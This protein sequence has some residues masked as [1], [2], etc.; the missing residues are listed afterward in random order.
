VASINNG[1]SDAKALGS[2]IFDDLK[3]EFA[4]LR[5]VRSQFGYILIDPR[6]VSLS[7]DNR[8]LRNVF[9]RSGLDHRNSDHWK[10]LLSVVAGALYPPRSDA[11]ARANERKKKWNIESTRAFFL[12]V[13]R[14]F[15]ET[16]KSII[17]IC[18]DL[19]ALAVDQPDSPYRAPSARALENKFSVLLGEAEA[20]LREANESWLGIDRAELQNLIEKI[21]AE[22][23][24]QR[25]K[26]AK[27][28]TRKERK[29]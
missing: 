5:I 24:E 6:T 20:H 27:L 11:A 1:I 2:R 7:K 17:S 21:K 29:S 22:R 12:E 3:A 15:I 14:T 16:G 9:K 26:R 10:Y 13:A 25:K 19:K 23:T 18:T 28:G 4:T 8:G